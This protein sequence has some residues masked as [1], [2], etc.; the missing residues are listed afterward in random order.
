MSSSGWEQRHISDRKAD[1]GWQLRCSGSLGNVS[2]ANLYT[3]SIKPD[4]NRHMTARYAT[5][6]SVDYKGAHQMQA[7]GSFKGQVGKEAASFRRQVQASR[8]RD[9][10]HLS[11]LLAKRLQSIEV[12]QAGLDMNA[13]AQR[14]NRRDTELADAV[15][16]RSIL[17]EEKRVSDERE[18]AKLLREKTDADMAKS[19]VEQEDRLNRG[20]VACKITREEDDARLARS[21]GAAD[22]QRYLTQKAKKASLK[23]HDEAVANMFATGSERDSDIDS[24][25]VH[26]ENECVALNGTCDSELHLRNDQYAVDAKLARA[27]QAADD[28]DNNVCSAESIH[29]SDIAWM[30]VIS[31]SRPSSA[32]TRLFS[33]EAVADKAIIP[34]GATSSPRINKPLTGS[35]SVPT[36]KRTGSLIANRA[37]TRT[38]RADQFQI[39]YSFLPTKGRTR[40]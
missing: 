15:M 32:T 39:P 35:Q 11:D 5:I 24:R 29:G 33:K 34:S 38:C 30:S 10:D 18:A 3:T 40:P 26:L 21:I 22:Q 31:S 16:A 27:L 20:Q 28:S 6:D 13:F 25:L 8:E 7:L 14:L 17:M 1:Q 4:L 9:N 36:L 19:M 23:V 12:R 2:V 37:S